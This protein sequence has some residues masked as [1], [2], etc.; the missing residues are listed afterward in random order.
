MMYDELAKRVAAATGREDLL[1]EVKREL[2]VFKELG[3]V[4]RPRGRKRT[5]KEYEIRHVWQAVVTWRLTT[6][7]YSIH[8]T[9]LA[10]AVVEQIRREAED[11]FPNADS[12]EALL[13]FLRQQPER[14][15]E[16]HKAYTAGQRR[17]F[18]VTITQGAEI[19]RLAKH[20]AVYRR[21]FTDKR[22]MP[23]FV[24]QIVLK[25]FWRALAELETGLKATGTSVI[26]R[27]DV[28]V[29]LSDRQRPREWRLSES[30]FYRAQTRGSGGSA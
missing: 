18:K 9:T 15:I 3:A 23:L 2:R 8:D 19:Q 4:S 6:R 10:E 17:T 30:L 24:Q 16:Y 25:Q 12:G 14:F 26:G 5:H 7:Q 22:R 20:A 1:D 11:A 21:G 27:E 29:E 28:T 13:Q